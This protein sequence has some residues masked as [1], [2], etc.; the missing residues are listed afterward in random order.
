MPTPVASKAPRGCRRLLFT[1]LVASSLVSAGAPADPS[2]CPGCAAARQE[3]G[4]CEIC[5]VGYVADVPIRSHYLWEVLDAHGHRL[6]L[7]TL[8][9]AGCLQAHVGDGYCEESRIGFVDGEAY[10]SRLTW[11]LAVSSRETTGS[12]TCPVCRVNAA[13][14]GWCDACEL[15]RVG[16]IVLHDRGSFDD[17][18]HDLEILA[19]ANEAAGRCEPC[20]AA[21]VTDTECPVC[22]VRY[23]E[24]KAVED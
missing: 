23:K 8:D 10:F 2:E 4:W 15:G 19:I 14:S 7:D 11:L 6:N 21:I 1:F 17:L 3:N 13:G 12:P 20:A 22:R 18:V 16:S 5:D 24:G 9:C